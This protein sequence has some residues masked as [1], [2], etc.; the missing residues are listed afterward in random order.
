[1]QLYKGL[2]EFM[3]VDIAQIAQE[4][5]NS[6]LHKMQL[7]HLEQKLVGRL[8][9]RIQILVKA[10]L[11]VRDQIENARKAE[12]ILPHDQ[13]FILDDL[14]EVHDALIIS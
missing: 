8:D 13:I 14:I 12:Q 7:V 3:R 4:G 11:I 5:N 2:L 6:L 9:K 10:R 1:M